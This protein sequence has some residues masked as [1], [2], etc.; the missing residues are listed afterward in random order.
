M[1]GTGTTT[2]ADIDFVWQANCRI[3]GCG[4]ACGWLWLWLECAEAEN[5]GPL[6]GE[7]L[8]LGVSCLLVGICEPCKLLL[9]ITRAVEAG[10]AREVCCG[11]V[12]PDD[13]DWS[14]G[15]DC[16]CG[17]TLAETWLMNSIMVMLCDT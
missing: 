12:V 11:G 6:S 14:E 7:V 5:S 15:E 2:P 1:P 13:I 4:G 3:I 8:V 16:C 17:L 9:D 10:E